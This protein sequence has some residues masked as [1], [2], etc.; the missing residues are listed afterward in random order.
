[1]KVIFLYMAF[2][3]L[4]KLPF[5]WQDCMSCNKGLLLAWRCA[6]VFSG[7]EVKLNT[8]KLLDIFSF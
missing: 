7:K 4:S 8:M 5:Q 1:M 2:S 3:D 6:N